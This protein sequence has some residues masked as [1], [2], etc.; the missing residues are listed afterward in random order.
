MSP[1]EFKPIDPKKAS[2]EDIAK[3]LDMLAKDNH[4][5][6]RVKAGELKGSK[7]WAEM[8]DEEKAKA[9]TYEQKR[10]AQIRLERA[11]YA[12]GVASGV[13]NAVT[14]DQIQAELASRA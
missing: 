10:Q 4:R 7:T 13:I 11:A 6:A 14:E 12:E 1:V 3:A 2:K 5:K 8:S 9:K